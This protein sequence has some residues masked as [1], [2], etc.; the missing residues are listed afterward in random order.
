MRIG[1]FFVFLFVITPSSVSAAERELAWRLGLARTS[2]DAQIPTLVF[3]SQDVEF[4]GSGLRFALEAKLDER[5]G[6]E[7]GLVDF[8][9]KQVDV[10]QSYHGSAAWAAL[11]PFIEAGPWTLAA[12]I[13]AAT[14]T[15]DI[16]YS[17]PV[18]MLGDKEISTE[19]FVGASATY[20]FGER[21]GIQVSIDRI[22]DVATVTGLDY[23]YG[24]R[25]NDEAPASTLGVELLVGTASA[26]P[27]IGSI[28]YA[29]DSEYDAVV[30]TMMQPESAHVLGLRV[31]YTSWLSFELAYF[32]KSSAT[33]YAGGYYDPQPPQPPMGPPVI[34]V[35]DVT[36]TVEFEGA[37]V[38]A[39][40][41]Y[42]AANDADLF[43]TLGALAQRETVRLRDS[44]SQALVYSDSD[45]AVHPSLG[46]GIRY[47]IIKGLALTVE[48]AR[49][50]GE[51][52]SRAM[53]GWSF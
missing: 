18:E 42:E 36:S 38:A 51:N 12:K 43:V 47:R 23:R 1:L 6:V 8:G 37:L 16:R 11:T 49:A 22:G 52:R 31:P 20:R 40:F 27:G 10:F 13:G 35:V 21:H 17:T 15:T 14:A 39:R 45:V 34:Y 48:I 33:H 4:D 2:V 53:L 9:S 41:E 24:W 25:V 5:L 7:F 28:R 29:I 50:D 32:P 26:T 19:L 46:V 30:D 44:H 3:G